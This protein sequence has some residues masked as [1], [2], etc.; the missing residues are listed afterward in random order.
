MIRFSFKRK[1]PTVT[2]TR[3]RPSQAQVDAALDRYFVRTGDELDVQRSQVVGKA[4]ALALGVAWSPVLG[5]MVR[6]ALGRMGGR[7][8]K[9]SNCRLVS[10]I[11]P[12]H[13]DRAD[14]IRVAVEL[15]KLKRVPVVGE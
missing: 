15:R 14:A 8:F 2:G 1:N 12:R 4:V 3:Y 6:G 11:R 7:L 9:F 13:F 10:G 5:Q